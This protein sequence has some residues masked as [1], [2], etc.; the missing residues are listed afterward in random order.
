MAQEEHVAR[1][2]QDRLSPCKARVTKPCGEQPRLSVTPTLRVVGQAQIAEIHFHVLAGHRR[3]HHADPGTRGEPSLHKASQ[4]RLRTGVAVLEQLVHDHVGMAGLNPLLNLL[5]KGFQG[6][7]VGLGRHLAA[8][9]L[10]H[11]LF[12]G[13]Q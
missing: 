1:L 3:T 13:Q 8:P 7:G 5:A 9:R 6:M 11:L 2:L 4:G 12:G 10:L